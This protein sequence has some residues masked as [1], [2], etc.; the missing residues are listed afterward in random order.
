MPGP[1]KEAARRL[2]EMT[3]SQQGFFTTKQAIR[4][5]FAEKTHSYHVNAGNWIREHRGIYRLADFPAPERPD[6]MLWYLWSQNRQ[7]VPEG[8]TAM[9][10]PSVFMNY[11]TSCHRSCT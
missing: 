4:S 2:H 1:Y 3:Q 10:R 6:L 7:E 5:G 9:R 8:P 11:R